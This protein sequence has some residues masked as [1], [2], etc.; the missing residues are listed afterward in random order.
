[1]KINEV[2][3]M[4]GLSVKTIRFYESKELLHVKRSQSRYREYSEDDITILQTI[5]LYRKCGLSIQDI[6]EILNDNIDVQEKLSQHIN[7]LRSQEESLQE[8]KDLCHNVIKAKGDLTSLFD[9][10]DFIE[11]DHYKEF[12]DA[13]DAKGCS[14]P[15]Q[16]FQTCLCL[17]PI[18]WFF[19]NTALGHYENLQFLFIASL[20][21]T[22]YLTLSWRS[23]IKQYKYGKERPLEGLAYF[24]LLLLIII[25]IIIIVFSVF[26]GV[27]VLQTKLFMNDSVFLYA[28]PKT[29]TMILILITVFYG[30]C[31]VGCCLKNRQTSIDD[32]KEYFFIFKRFYKYIIPISFVALLI[33][34]FNVTTVSPTEM[35]S[36]S[37]I[38]PLGRTYTFEDIESV[39]TGFLTG[40]IQIMGSQGDFFYNVTMKDN[41]TIAF[42][43]TQTLSQYEDDTYSEIEYLDK[44]IMQRSVKKNSSTDGVEHAYLDQYYIDRFIRIIKNK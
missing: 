5:K 8:Q 20:L 18:L 6:Y 16:L 11:S 37:L 25:G 31:F 35:K 34:I 29:S 26:I 21:V 28:V 1:M 22:V 13:L 36:Y 14:L 41:K 17:G 23:F 42:S 40:Y 39:E 19:F 4:T 30:Y 12:K 33:V 32:V 9:Y 27:T 38:N 15:I 2:Q 43:N 24:G 3:K 7:L 44:L 10:V